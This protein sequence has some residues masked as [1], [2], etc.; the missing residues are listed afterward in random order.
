MFFAVHFLVFFRVHEN[1]IMLI[2]RN[3]ELVGPSLAC[4]RFP[5]VRFLLLFLEDIHSPM[6]VRTL[7]LENFLKEN[8]PNHK[9]DVFSGAVCVR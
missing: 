4:C 8:S 9:V 2:E 5:R 6:T 3:Y 7:R 1:G